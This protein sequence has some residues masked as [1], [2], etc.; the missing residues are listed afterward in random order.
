[1]SWRR[2]FWRMNKSL[3][4]TTYYVR[5][6]RRVVAMGDSSDSSFCWKKLEAILE[7]SCTLCFMF[8]TGNHHRM[9]WILG[10]ERYHVP[11]PFGGVQAER[12]HWSRRIAEAPRFLSNIICVTPMVG[13]FRGGATVEKC[14]AEPLRAW[15]ILDNSHSSR[16]VPS[17]LADWVNL[18]R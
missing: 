8:W 5:L 14:H 3:A 13:W 15:M 17:Q 18:D 6:Q 9:D 12:L 1:M 7:S 10:R 16:H 4:E 2:R 11:V